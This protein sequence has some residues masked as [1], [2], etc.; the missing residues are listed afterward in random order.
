MGT[1]QLLDSVFLLFNHTLA[2]IQNSEASGPYEQFPCM[3]RINTL[4]TFFPKDIVDVEQGFTLTAYE[5]VSKTNTIM[6]HKLG[7]LQSEHTV[8]HT[9]LA[10]WFCRLEGGD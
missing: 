6:C 5:G 2:N 10:A 3:E 8:L 4:C 1:F 9:A 7:V